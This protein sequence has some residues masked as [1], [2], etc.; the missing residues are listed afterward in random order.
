M[1]YKDKFVGMNVNGYCEGYFGHSYGERIVIASGENWVVTKKESGDIEFARFWSPDM[2]GE[3]IKSWNRQYE[4][5][6]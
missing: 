4:E 3:V 6:D 2:M 1:N 5:L